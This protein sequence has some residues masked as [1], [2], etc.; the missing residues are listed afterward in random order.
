M[1]NIPSIDYMCTSCGA[2][3]IYQLVAAEERPS[4]AQ[5]SSAPHEMTSIDFRCSHCGATATYMLVPA[6]TATT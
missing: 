2:R 4:E 5:V 1:T 6:A 3:T